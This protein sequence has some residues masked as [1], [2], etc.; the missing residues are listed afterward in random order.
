MQNLLSKTL[1]SLAI[2]FMVASPTV[3]QQTAPVDELLGKLEGVQ[4]QR[5]DLAAEAEKL[6]KDIRERLKGQ[7]ERLK[8]L[9]GLSLPDE[10]PPAPVIP[11]NDPLKAKVAAAFKA[12]PGALDQKM[13]DAIQLMGVYAA[14]KELKPADNPSIATVADLIARVRNLG[15]APAASQLAG[16]RKVIGDEFAAVLKSPAEPMTAD[17]WKAAL[18][19]FARIE[20]ALDEVTK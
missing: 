9:T 18:E 3:A 19:L 13:R 15:T 12:D 4:K 11:D 7:S 8:E 17:K 14:A 20:S 10:K 5:K 16:T 2:V 6:A 1:L